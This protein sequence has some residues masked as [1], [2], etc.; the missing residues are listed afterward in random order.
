V[1]RYRVFITPTAWQEMRELPGHVRQRVKKA[2]NE[3]SS[4]PN[5]PATQK[6]R[7]PDLDCHLR[8][9]RL[10]RWRILYIVT[11][12]DKTVDVIAIRKRPPYRYEDLAELLNKLR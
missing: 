6:L 10:D 11:D 8:R 3:L 7:T 12:K 9:L 1:S 5:P 2:I 4:N